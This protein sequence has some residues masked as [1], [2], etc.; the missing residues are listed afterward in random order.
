MTHDLREI[1]RMAE[2]RKAHPSAVILD[3][4]TIQCTPESGG[5]AGYDGAKRRKG[6]KVH[7]AVDT[8]GHLLALHVTP[9]DEQDRDQ[10]GSCRARCRKSPKN[11]WN[12]PM[13][14]RV[15]PAIGPPRRRKSTIYNLKSSSCPKPSAASSCCRAAGS[16]NAPSA[17]WPAADDSPETTNASPP[18]SPDSTSSPSPA[19]CSTDYWPIIHNRLL[20]GTK[21][22]LGQILTQSR[23]AVSFPKPRT[24]LSAFTKNGSRPRPA[25]GSR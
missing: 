16:S 21:V 17:G 4:R 24:T 12:W 2:G 7:M 14:I 8:L 10:V 9:A 22:E 13:L 15:T 11:R 18:P 1:L 6:S 3:S 19:Y 20:L 5:R 23:P 25:S